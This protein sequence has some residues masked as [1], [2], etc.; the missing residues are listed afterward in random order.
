MPRRPP[1]EPPPLLDEEALQES[2]GP[3]RPPVRHRS[4]LSLRYFMYWYYSGRHTRTPILARLI[5]ADRPLVI[6]VYESFLVIAQ[7]RSAC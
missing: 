3:R 1:L 7:R 2:G 5:L 4:R 6:S